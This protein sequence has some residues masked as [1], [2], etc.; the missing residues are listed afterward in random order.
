MAA[1]PPLETDRFGAVAERR[2]K[3]ADDGLGLSFGEGEGLRMLGI[4]A[5]FGL[6]EA[7]GLVAEVEL[8][9]AVG[10]VALD[11]AR[12]DGMVHFG[13][14]DAGGGEGDEDGATVR[15][16]LRLG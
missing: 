1:L 4:L 13:V 10:A 6:G 14:R 3:P 12:L 16:D 5:E 11:V 15:S 2:Q 8:A 9:L 7:G